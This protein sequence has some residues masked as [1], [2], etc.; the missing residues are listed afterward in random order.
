L[1]DSRCLS[2]FSRRVPRH[3]WIRKRICRHR[4]S[5]AYSVPVEVKEE[6]S[7]IDPI[8]PCSA[9]ECMYVEP[10]HELL[11]FHHHSALSHH[12]FLSGL[13]FR[14]GHHCFFFLWKPSVLQQVDCSVS[15]KMTCTP[16]EDWKYRPQVSHGSRPHRHL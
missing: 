13:H 11:L 10:A 16:W 8:L 3:R 15:P 1:L 12:D 2:T 14:P 4:C 6:E 7:M 5:E 9:V